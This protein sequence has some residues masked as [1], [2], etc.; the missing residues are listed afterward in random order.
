MLLAEIKNIYH[1]ELV[2][3]YPKT[4]IDSFFYSTIE[5]FLQLERF[6]LVIQPQL[7]LTK[8]E[9]QPLFETLSRLKQEEPLQYILGEIYFMDFKLKVNEHTL[10]PRPETEELISWVLET[11]Q[12]KN[13]IPTTY[14]NESLK[15]LDIGTGSGCIAIALA[16]ALPHAHVTAI[17][18]SNEALQLAQENARLNTVKVNFVQADILA[19][20]KIE[21]TEFDI[22]I[23]NPPYVREL[24]KPKMNNNVK[25]YEPPTALFVP[26]TNPLLFYEAIANFAGSAL[27]N[28][29]QLYLEIN[30]YLGKETKSLFAAHNFTAIELKK[31]IFENQR[32]L[33]CKKVNK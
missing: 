15:V 9:E 32:M 18:I 1:N 2:E 22:I 17:D 30:Q 26:D 8:S 4:E 14:A 7:T 10:I 24:E 6:A 11:S 13:T 27:K 21:W 31:D 12:N 20:T 33:R 3:L 25:L 28:E 16:K 19:I 5:H 23:S 29:G